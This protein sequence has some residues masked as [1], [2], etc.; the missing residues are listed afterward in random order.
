M[1][2]EP[3]RPRVEQP[4]YQPEIIP[5]GEDMRRRRGSFESIF[6]HVE[7]GPDGVRRASLKRPGPF[8]IALVLLGVGLVVA[9]FFVLLSAL[10]LLWIPVAIVGILLALFSSAGRDYWRRI[11]GWFGSRMP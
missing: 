1:S 8:T 5:P 6:I 3:D 4:R 7:E 10:V 11:R 9:L 2:N